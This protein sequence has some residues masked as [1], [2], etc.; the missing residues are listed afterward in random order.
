MML[1]LILTLNSYAHDKP[2]KCELTALNN[3]EI[4]I[5]T[6]SD[7]RFEKYAGLAHFCKFLYKEAK[8][9]CER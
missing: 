8:E 2:N 1:T 9:R 4:C 3:Y 7:Q 6:A 5:L